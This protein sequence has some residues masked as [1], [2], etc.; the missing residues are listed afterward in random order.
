MRII[1]PLLSALSIALVA[2]CQQA[3][4]TPAEQ[5]VANADAEADALDQR[6]RGL[7]EQADGLENQAKQLEKQADAV[8]AAGKARAAALNTKAV[9]DANRASQPTTTQPASPPA[10]APAQ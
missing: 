8:R 3:P 6:A 5:A 9:A 2:G 4:P 1:V 7:T 10:S